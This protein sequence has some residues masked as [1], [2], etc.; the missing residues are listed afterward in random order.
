MLALTILAFSIAVVVFAGLAA[1]WSYFGANR[2]L[3][4]NF[5]RVTVGG[6]TG[7]VAGLVLL[8]VSGR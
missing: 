5:L 3:V 1:R 8:A 7:V 6:L 4:P 2:T